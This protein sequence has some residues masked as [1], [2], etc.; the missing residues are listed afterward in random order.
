MGNKSILIVED[1]PMN[2]QLVRTLLSGEGYDWRFAAQCRRALNVL[3]YLQP[4]L[5]LMDIQLP[6]KSGLELTRQLRANPELNGASIVALSGYSRKDD[7]Q[8]CLNAGCNGYI[9]KPIDTSTF[10]SLVRSFIDKTSRAVPKGASDVRDLLRDI[11]NNFIA[12]SLEELAG[13]LSEDFDRDRLLR[14]LH[15]LGWYRGH[16]RNARRDRPG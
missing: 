5:I 12:E 8:S 3:A 14:A 1:D 15:R 7:E 6:G 4:G 10:R 16:S 13:L 2:V 9:G 11:R